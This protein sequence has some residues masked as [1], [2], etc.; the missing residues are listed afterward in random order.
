VGDD[1]WLLPRATQRDL[2]VQDSARGPGG[3]LR[4]PEVQVPGV[5]LLKFVDD[6]PIGS[7]K[8]VGDVEGSVLLPHE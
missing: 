7:E 2:L 1:S 8:E 3:D 4:N 6:L 5:P